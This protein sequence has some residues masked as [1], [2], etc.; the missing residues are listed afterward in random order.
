MPKFSLPYNWSNERDNGQVISADKIQAQDESLL[1]AVNQAVLTD[2]SRDMQGNLRMGNKKIQNLQDGKDIQDAVTMNQFVN[3]RVNFALGLPGTSS[4]SFNNTY[5][6]DFTSGVS[7]NAM[8]KTLKDGFRMLMM[9]TVENT[10]PTTNKVQV[11][12]KGLDN[13][14]PIPIV[15][16]NGQPLVAGAIKANS[17]REFVY[18]EREA[19][20][21]SSSSSSSSRNS[22]P[23]SKGVF[24][25]VNNSSNFA[26]VNLSNVTFND[27]TDARIWRNEKR[28]GLDEVNKVMPEEMDYFTKT[29]TAYFGSAF[30]STDSTGYTKYVW[31]ESRL[32]YKQLHGYVLVKDFENKD[33]ARRVYFTN[34]TPFAFRGSAV[35]AYNGNVDDIII[36]TTLVSRDN[37]VSGFTLYTENI[38]LNGFT[39]CLYNIKNASTNF[40]GRIMF[41]VFFNKTQ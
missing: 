7:Q 11:I 19:S 18:Y 10:T 32:G 36:S 26:T 5:V 4:S 6:M 31:Q 16:A 33:L 9:A 40:T 14:S 29:G 3:G 25:L 41:N 2:G 39:I 13:N 24:Y 27:N 21:T 1:N 17:L 8:V 38:D 28:R 12:I 23:K 34:N 20:S 35:G 15:D 22:A 37:K 30:G